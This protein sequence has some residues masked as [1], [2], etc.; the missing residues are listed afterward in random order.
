MKRK[1]IFR[2]IINAFALAIVAWLL[3]GIRFEGIPD[4]ILAALVLGL[5]NSFLRPILVIIFFPISLVTLGVFL[6]VVNALML[7]LTARI[8]GGFSIAGFWSAFGGALLL[9]F[10]SWLIS[11]FFP[12]KS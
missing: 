11:G 12:K 10:F 8:V 6:F 4:L 3:P 9:S 1:F 5:I 2:W 7:L